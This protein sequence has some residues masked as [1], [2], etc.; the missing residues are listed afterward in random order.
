L[1]DCFSKSA[2]AFSSRFPSAAF[3]K[4]GGANAIAVS[5]ADCLKNFLLLYLFRFPDP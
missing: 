3:I 1:R 2:E 4:E 5:A